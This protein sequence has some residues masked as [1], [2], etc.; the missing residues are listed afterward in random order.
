MRANRW[1]RQRGLAPRIGCLARRAV[2]TCDSR[3]GR[4]D[5]HLVW[6]VQRLN[7]QGQPEGSRRQRGRL[8]RAMTLARAAAARVV[9][10]RRAG[11]SGLGIACAR[12][13]LAAAHAARRLLLLRRR[14]RWRRRRWRLLLLLH[15]RQHRCAQRGSQLRHVGGAWSAD[16]G[17]G[18]TGGL[19]HVAGAPVQASLSRRPGRQR[20]L[21]LGERRQSAH[22]PV[23]CGTPTGLATGFMQAD[24]ANAAP[25]RGRV[26]AEHKGQQLGH[27]RVPIARVE[28][29]VKE[30]AGDGVG[31]TEN[32][33]HVEK[34]LTADLGRPT[35]RGWEPGTQDGRDSG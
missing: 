10:A 9:A 8:A 7:P 24:A 13:P 22:G 6:P 21:R 20:P 30:L 11:H 28:L 12:R 19:V 23:L 17:R 4:L 18:V 14:R 25:T 33:Q 26:R 3:H 5:C 31:Q 1:P 15:H 2:P 35:G 32:A 16:A 27:R 29:L 34:L